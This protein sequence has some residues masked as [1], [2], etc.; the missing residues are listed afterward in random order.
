MQEKEYHLQV[1]KNVDGKVQG[2]SKRATLC[3]HG[4]RE[5]LRQGFVRRAVVLYE[6][7]WND[8]KVYATCTGYV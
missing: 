5:R 3:I 8:G 4:T 2:R 1:V 7:I 6:K